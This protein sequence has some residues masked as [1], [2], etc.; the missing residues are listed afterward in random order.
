MGHTENDA[1]NNSSIVACVFNVAV[2]LGGRYR[3]EN[4]TRYKV[5]VIM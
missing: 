4:I 2:K 3:W 1:S 5:D